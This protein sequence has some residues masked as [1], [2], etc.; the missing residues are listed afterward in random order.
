MFKHALK[1]GTII[2]VISILYVLLLYVIGMSA[3]KLLSRLGLLILIVGIVIAT[4]KYRNNVLGGGISFGKCFS[5]GL[6][7]SVIV[8]LISSVFS[9][10]LYTYVAPEMWQEFVEL[11]QQ[12]ALDKL[13]S[14]G[15]DIDDIDGVMEMSSMFVKPLV[16]S[17][18]SFFSIV[19]YG[20]I[21]SLIASIFIKK[22]KPIFESEDNLTE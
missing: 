7:V 2:G 1:W 12:Q 21:V 6:L 15:M 3:N 10:I 18:S 9:Y 13:E 5:Y 17:I 16:I 11:S 22:E 14:S 19:L 4:I 20:G 8:A